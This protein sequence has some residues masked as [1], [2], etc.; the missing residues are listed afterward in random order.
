VRIPKLKF[1][2]V[3]AIKVLLV[4]CVLVFSVSIYAHKIEPNWLDVTTTEIKLPNLERAFDGYR[5]VQI[6]D[7]HAGDGIDRA[8]LEKVVELVNAQNPDL[9][10]ITGDLVSR[11]PRQHVNL[12]DTLTKLHP[13]DVTLSVLGN[14]DVFNDATPVRKAIAKAGITLLE[15]T[16]YTLHRDRSTLHIAGVGDVFFKLDDLDRVLT[17]LPTTGAAIMLAH[18]PDFAD[19][20]A[21]TGRFGLQLSGHSHGG[22]IRIPFYGGYVPDFARKYPRGRYQVGNMIQY[23]SRGIGM[24][25]IYARFNCRPEISVFNLVAS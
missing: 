16:V 2:V 21:A 22:Q 25:K 14:H 19:E 12:L 6:T 18:E 8:Q 5:I 11:L 24:I 20:A 1:L 17:Q 15:N 7:L 3:R 13:R 23:T 10:V 9:V 4:G